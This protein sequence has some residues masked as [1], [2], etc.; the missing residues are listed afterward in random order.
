MVGWS[1]R[2]SESRKRFNRWWATLTPEQKAAYERRE[3]ETD[4]KFFRFCWFFFPIAIMVMAWSCVTSI[5]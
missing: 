1:R 5:K 2:N 4:R 3:A